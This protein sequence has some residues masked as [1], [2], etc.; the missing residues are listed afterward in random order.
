ME[1]TTLESN[2]LP[3][4]FAWKGTLRPYNSVQAYNSVDC[5]K[6]LT[7]MSRERNSKTTKVAEN[8][9][10]LGTEHLSTAFSFDLFLVLTVDVFCVTGH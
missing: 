1:V 9:L 4:H 10:V 3:F 6:H 2:A 5:Q 7:L 8:K